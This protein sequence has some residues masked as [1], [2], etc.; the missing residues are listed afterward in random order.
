MPGRTGQRPT[1]QPISL[2]AEAAQSSDDGRFGRSCRALISSPPALRQGLWKTCGPM[3]DIVCTAVEAALQVSASMMLRDAPRACARPFA[4][5]FACAGLTVL[6][7]DRRFGIVR[8]CLPDHR[9]QPS[10]TTRAKNRATHQRPAVLHRV[11]AGAAPALARARR[12]GAG[13]A[14]GIDAVLCRHRRCGGA[15]PGGMAIA[16]APPERGACVRVRFPY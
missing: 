15:A 5:L 6:Y 11:V 1:R 3:V 13:R 14:D 4:E 7:N 8:G 9:S 10:W 16:P 12:D 2:V